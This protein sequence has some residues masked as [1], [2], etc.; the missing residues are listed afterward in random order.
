[1]NVPDHVHSYHDDGG[2]DDEGE[3]DVGQ[4]DEDLDVE[5]L[6]YNV[7]PDMLL[8]C[9]NRGFNNFETLNKASRDLLYE[10]CKGRDKERTV[11][12]ITLELLKLKASNGWSGTSFSALLELLTKILSK[13]NGL[14]TSSYL[15]KKIICPLI[16]G[17]E[18]NSCLSEPLYLIPKRTQI[19]REVSNVQY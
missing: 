15:V 4:D 12:W 17:V 13:P 6:I 3:D 1:M 19:Q 16:L 7:A 5:E 2:K 11:L 8:Q 10:N 9:R 14:P 18:K